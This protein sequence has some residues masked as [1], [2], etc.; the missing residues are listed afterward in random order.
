M[1]E[2]DAWGY[3]PT[4]QMMR[5][6][7]SSMEKAYMAILEQSDISFFDGRLGHV[8]EAARDM[9]ERTWP[10][11]SERRLEP[12]E[13]GAARLYAYCLAHSLGKAG[14]EVAQESLPNDEDLISLIREALP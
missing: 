10:L 1:T 13:E 3:D 6:V 4:V 14:I 9:F 12:A 5:N 8:R 11:V 7:F 2:R